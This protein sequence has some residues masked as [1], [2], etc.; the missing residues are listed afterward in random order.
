MPRDPKF[1]QSTLKD[2]SGKAIPDGDVGLL[3]DCTPSK[4]V[5][6]LYGFETTVVTVVV[7]F[8]AIN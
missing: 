8:T 6:Q 5:A 2:I 3:S 4:W 7:V 1:L